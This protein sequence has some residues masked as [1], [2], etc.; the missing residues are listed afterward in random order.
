MISNNQTGIEVTGSGTVIEGNYI[1]PKPDGETAFADSGTGV[2]VN[3][4]SNVT[5]GGTLPG[6]GNVIS[7]LFQDGDPARYDDRR[8]DP[9]QPDRSEREPG[10]R[11][12]H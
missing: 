7:G 2:T 4:G 8:R 11:V 10:D 1:G 6:A 9:G 3:G 12:R 5:I